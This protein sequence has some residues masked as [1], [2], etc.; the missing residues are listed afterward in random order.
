MV[1]WVL[2]KNINT[3]RLCLKH[4]YGDRNCRLILWRKVKKGLE[5][6]WQGQFCR[7]IKKNSQEK[8]VVTDK[9]AFSYQSMLDRFLN[10]L[11]ARRCEMLFTA[12]LCC[13]ERPWLFSVLPVLVHEWALYL[14]ASLQYVNF[15]VV[16]TIARPLLFYWYTNHLQTWFG[17]HIMPDNSL[18]LN[19]EISVDD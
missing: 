15:S 18:L 12:F 4:W 19:T 10:P 13:T 9:I 7:M 5:F 2:L 6:A 11:S 8:L 3:T 17:E 16:Q 14:H 1:P